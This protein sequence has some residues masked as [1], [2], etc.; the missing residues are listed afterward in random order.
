MIRSHRGPGGGYSLS[1]EAKNISLYEIV[2]LM[3]DQEVIRDDL[4]GSLW[5]SLDRHMSLQMQQINLSEALQNSTISIEQSTKGLSSSGLVIAAKK[6][7][8]P[9]QK[10][11]VRLL[12][13]VKPR[14]GPSSVFTFGKYLKST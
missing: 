3:G 7:K 9:S 1:R 4:G 11:Q 10:Q 14:M 5:R 2:C 8:N 12:K 13:N 6:T